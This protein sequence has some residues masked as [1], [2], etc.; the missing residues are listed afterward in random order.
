MVGWMFRVMRSPLIPRF[1][2]EQ[3]LSTTTALLEATIR[4][5]LENPDE[6]QCMCAFVGQT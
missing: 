2:L 4:D 1:E 3:S 6:H 5:R